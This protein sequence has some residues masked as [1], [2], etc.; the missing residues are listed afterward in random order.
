MGQPTVLLAVAVS[1]MFVSFKARRDM[2]AGMW[3]SVLLL[4]PQ[5]AV[6]F[7]LFILWQRRWYAV[8][9]AA[10]GALALV[11]LG[12]VTGGLGSLLRYPAVLADIGDLHNEIAGPLLMMNWRAIVLAIRPGI[13]EQIGLAIVWTLSL[14][15]MLASLL[16]WRGR[17]DPDSH[18]FN[19]RFCALS[20][21][22]LIG[23]YHSHLHGAALLAVP[24]AAAWAT[25]LHPATRI[26]LLVAIYAPTFFVLWI[27][28]IV[29][30]LAVSTDAN[31]P[32][33]TVW[34]N[35]LPAVLYVAA[36]ALLCIDALRLHVPRTQ[37]STVRG[38]A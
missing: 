8:A 37:L 2:R 1:E 19:V 11:T 29:G 23:S 14:L 6:L 38:Y 3:L 13:G 28:G 15:T 22:A 7:G 4:K 25:P 21:A 17:W 36:F 16:L 10:I 34:P 9:G 12:L 24:I 18:E 5:Y 32:L 33:W 30:H 20:V 26:A 35:V 31:V 27:T